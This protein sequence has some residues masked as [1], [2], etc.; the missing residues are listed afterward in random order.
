[1]QARLGQGVI[2]VVCPTDKDRES[3]GVLC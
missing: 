1:V 2:F 3:G